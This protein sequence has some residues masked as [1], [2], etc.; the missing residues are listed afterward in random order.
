MSAEYARVDL[1]LRAEYV[2]A[3]STGIA[4]RASMAD[5][6]E[7][8]LARDCD[9]AETGVFRVDLLRGTK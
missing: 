5:A 1:C 4:A 7:A 3:I 8:W 9:R 2:R 6:I